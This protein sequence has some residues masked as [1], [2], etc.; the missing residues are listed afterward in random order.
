M[1]IIQ[2]ADII[3]DIL[4]LKWDKNF[5]DKKTKTFSKVQKFIDSESIR[6]MTPYVPFKNGILSESAKLGTVI[7]SG[8]IHQNMPYAHYM[9]YGKVYGPN[10]P[11]FENGI[12]IGYFSPKGK[13]KHLTGK[14][15]EYNTTKHPQAG[16]M[17]FERM[18][19]DH[20]DEI[21]RGAVKLSGGKTE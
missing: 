8:E 15:I 7:G 4:N 11:I 6:L 5:S 3:S 14:N 17:W 18:K 16:K 2:P 1:K 12:V 9:Y 13:A 21:L 10:I 20:K 19:A